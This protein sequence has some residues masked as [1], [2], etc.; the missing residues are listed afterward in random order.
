ME[1]TFSCPAHVLNRHLSARGSI[2]LPAEAAALAG[3][4]VRH[5]HRLPRELWAPHPQRCSRPGW[6]GPWAA[7]SGGWQLPIAQGWGWMIYEVPSS[8][9]HSVI[10]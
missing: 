3:E 8:L 1:G 5:W 6:M 2:P 4:K 10:P 7:S 9:S